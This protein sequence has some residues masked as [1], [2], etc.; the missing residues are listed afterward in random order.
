[1][2]KSEAKAIIKA[3]ERMESELN[4]LEQKLK[5]QELAYFQNYWGNHIRNTLN[6]DGFGCA[7]VQR[8][9]EALEGVPS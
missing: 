8:A 3:K 1:M 9:L 5:G 6:S 7:P 2:N 4:K